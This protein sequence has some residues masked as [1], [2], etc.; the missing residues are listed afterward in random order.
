MNNKCSGVRDGSFSVTQ[1]A[2]RG[3]ALAY[4]GTFDPV[5]IEEAKVG[6]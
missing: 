2:S 3:C 6:A 1:K 5:G 4:G